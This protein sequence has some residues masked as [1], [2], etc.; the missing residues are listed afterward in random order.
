MG[1]LVEGVWQSGWY[2]PDDKGAFVRPDA[3]FRDRVSADGASGFRAEAG[4]YHLYVSYACPWAH[5]TLIVRALRGLEDVIPVTA[6]DPKMGDGGWAFGDEVASS[7]GIA[8]RRE[9]VVLLAATA[10]LTAVLGSVVGA[11]GFVGL[12]LPHAARFLVGPLHLRLVPVTALIGATFM[13]WVDALSRVAFSPS[14][15]PVGVGTALVGVPCF[16]AVMFRRRR[17]L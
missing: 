2:E 8:V 1:Q 6:V 16:I 7:L 13:V 11:V 12:V 17:S 3:E 9:R 4:R 10:L 14:P 15:L 5:R